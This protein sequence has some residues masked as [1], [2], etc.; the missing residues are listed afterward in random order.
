MKY[1]TD[2]FSNFIDAHIIMQCVD[3][4]DGFKSMVVICI[5]MNYNQPFHEFN[6]SNL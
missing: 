5:I 4:K 2:M 1:V 6:Q 3:I